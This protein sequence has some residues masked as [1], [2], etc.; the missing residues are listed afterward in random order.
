MFCDKLI[1]KTDVL[2]QLHP[3]GVF[4]PLNEE[5]HHC[6]P[7]GQRVWKQGLFREEETQL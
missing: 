5:E 2:R 3:L 7:P 4:P 1:A 6:N